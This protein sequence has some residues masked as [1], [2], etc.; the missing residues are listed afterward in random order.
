[1]LTIEFNALPERFRQKISVQSGTGCWIWIAGGHGG[2]RYGGYSPTHSRKVYAH[3]YSFEFFF[4]PVPSGLQIDHLCRNKRCVNPLHMEATT[5][6]MNTMRGMNFPI[7]DG[8]HCQKGHP[9]FGPNLYMEGSTRRCRTCLKARMK[10]YKQRQMRWYG[11]GFSVYHN[12]D[13]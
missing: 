13:K 4:G 1:M 12:K 8:Q 10:R 3:R 2:G 7:Q 9:L 5:G 11:Q 6:Q